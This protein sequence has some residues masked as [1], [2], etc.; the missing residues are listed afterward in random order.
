MKSLEDMKEEVAICNH[1]KGW[2][3][4]P[5]TFGDLIA[6]LHSEASEMLDSYRIRG[7]RVHTTSEGKPD[8]VASEAA[9]VLIRL[10]DICDIYDIDLEKE[11]E[12]KMAYNRTRPYR[13]GGK[14]L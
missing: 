12:R 8:D 2:R 5:L 11:Y 13:H 4:S 10:L 7:L 14:L 9:D 1:D 3:N 6:L